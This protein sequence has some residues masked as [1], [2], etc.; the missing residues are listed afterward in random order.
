MPRF[1]VDEING[2]HA[3]ISGDDAKHISRVLRMS[4]GEEVTLCDGNG[5]DYIA[6]IDSMGDSIELTILSMSENIAEP[7]LELNLYQAIPKLD[8]MDLI[9]QKSVELGVSKIT[10]VL[11]ERCVSR[12]NKQSMSRKIERYQKIALSAA[13]QSG[14]GIV[15]QIMPM[16]SYQEAVEEVAASTGILFYE[17]GGESLNKLISKNTHHVS[18]LIGSE[19]GF[20]VEEVNLAKESGIKIATLGK[21]IL[22]AETAPISAISIIMHL[23]GNM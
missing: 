4:I 10:P 5:H 22:R 17:C 15:P 18:I 20:S 6:K 2:G 7:T 8:K 23:S 16:I 9:V 3:Y 12:P 11:T 14:R 13:K 1:F 19:G 21:R